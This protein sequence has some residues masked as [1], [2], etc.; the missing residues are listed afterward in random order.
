MTRYHTRRQVTVDTK[1]TR[2]TMQPVFIELGT[3]RIHW[4][5]VMM[6][7]AFLAA[8]LNWIVLGKRAGRSPAFCSDLLFW[9]MLS[10][11]G[12][13]RLAYVLENWHAFTDAPWRMLAVQEGGLVFYGGV[14]GAAVALV[15]IARIRREQLAA[16]VDFTITSVPLAHLLGRVGCFLNGCCYGNRTAS[17][18][19]VRFPALSPA[20]WSQQTIQTMPRQR[21]LE[22][23][24][25]AMPRSLPVHPVQLYEAAGNL[26]LY[27][28]I[29]VIFRRRHR[30]GRVTAA[31][32]T[33]YAILR[34]TVECFRGDHAERV[35]VVGLSIAQGVSLILA[36]A[37]VVLLVLTRSTRD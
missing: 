20:W 27:L 33:G 19:G 10:G 22:A 30:P 7:L 28:V 16:L 6:A 1:N 5:G 3:L 37:G 21:E 26:V 34:F 17:R 8:L 32:L 9:I 18:L 24:V 12:G 31:Y 36:L 13:A 29:L 23:M 4:Y 2:G 35:A 15:V 14:A 11:I 25:E